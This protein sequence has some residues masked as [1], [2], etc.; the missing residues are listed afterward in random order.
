MKSSIDGFYKFFTYKIHLFDNWAG[1]P[2]LN[3]IMEYEVVRAS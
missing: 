3:N 1:Y 2:W